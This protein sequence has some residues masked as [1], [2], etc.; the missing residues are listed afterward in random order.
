MPEEFITSFSQNLTNLLSLPLNDHSFLETESE[1][2]DQNREA[3]GQIN[4]FPH[5]A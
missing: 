3:P 4:A 5:T 1:G 2:H